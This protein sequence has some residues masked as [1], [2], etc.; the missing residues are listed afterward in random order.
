MNAPTA[1]SL[2]LANSAGRGPAV[3]SVLVIR[4]DVDEHGAAR[5]PRH[6]RGAQ[7]LPA[8]TH[9]RIDAGRARSYVNYW[10]E[11]AELVRGCA[12]VEIT[13]AEPEG[14]AAVRRALTGGHR[15]EVPSAC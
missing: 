6:L 3:R 10:G 2:R 11:L 12:T 8:G 5:L 1:R 14:L 13:G 15:G 4:L 7:G 9:C